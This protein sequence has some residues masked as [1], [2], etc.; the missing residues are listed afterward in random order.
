MQGQ[1]SAPAG[2]LLTALSAS[3]T[4]HFSDA[5]ESTMPA[6]A[7]LS[8]PGHNETHIR[9]H[10]ATSGGEAEQAQVQAQAS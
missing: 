2:T 10:V 6:R 3:V 7:S 5:S 1:S 4:S 9:L 8:Q